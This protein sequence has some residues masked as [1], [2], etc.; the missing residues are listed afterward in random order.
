MNQPLSER[1][2]EQIEGYD[3]LTLDYHVQPATEEAT[4]GQ[5]IGQIQVNG[6]LHGESYAVDIRELAKSAS[7]NG[8]VDPILW[9]TNRR[10]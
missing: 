3:Q 7:V 4:T 5:L 10:I 9:T 1:F 2:F 8:Q 6:V